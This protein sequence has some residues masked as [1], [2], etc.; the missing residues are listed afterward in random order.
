MTKSVADLVKDLALQY[1]KDN[2]TKLVACTAVPANYAEALSLSTAERV[3]TSADF[4][5]PTTVGDERQLPVDAQIDI[6]ITIEGLITHMVWIDT[7]NLDILVINNLVT[8]YSGCVARL[9]SLAA[10]TI[11]LGKDA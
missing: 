11:S 1:I 2:A 8:P 5:V 6:P 7:V 3:L 4:G 9:F 10:T